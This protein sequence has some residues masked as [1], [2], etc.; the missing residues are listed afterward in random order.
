MP[1]ASIMPSSFCVQLSPPSV[2]LKMPRT[3]CVPSQ[4]ISG[5]FG[6]I[7]R[8]NTGIASPESPVR[9]VTP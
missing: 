6:S 3:P 9:A 4:M 5:S 2:D 8:Q 7:V 1:W